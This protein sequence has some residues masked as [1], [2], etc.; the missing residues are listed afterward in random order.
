LANPHLYNYFLFLNIFNIKKDDDRDDIE[1]VNTNS[2]LD[3]QETQMQ[4]NTNLNPVNTLDNIIVPDGW[5]CCIDRSNKKYFYNET[6]KA[7][8]YLHKD[9]EGKPY[10]YNSEG[11]SIWNLPE[12]NVIISNFVFIN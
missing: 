4:L 6:T 10:Y 11:E 1:Y 2:Q 8:W 3:K 7:K 12:Q 9:S 5:L